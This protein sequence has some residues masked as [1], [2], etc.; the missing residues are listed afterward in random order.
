MALPHFSCSTVK[1]MCESWLAKAVHP[2]EMGEASFLGK[3]CFNVL[4]HWFLVESPQWLSTGTAEEP[5]FDIVSCAKSWD[6]RDQNRAR[7]RPP[8]TT[9][10]PSGRGVV[11]LGDR[12]RPRLL[13]DCQRSRPGETS[14]ASADWFALRGRWC[15]SILV[16]PLWE[17]VHANTGPI[18][19]ISHEPGL[20]SWPDKLHWL[21]PA[22]ACVLRVSLRLWVHCGPYQ[23]A[24][25][26]AN[27]HARIIILSGPF[28]WTDVWCSQHSPAMAAGLTDHIWTVQELLTSVFVPSSINTS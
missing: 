15:G 2:D 20:H 23:P 26:S 17:R 22:T 5:V 14:A 12:W 18:G 16:L 1:R 27:K 11:G 9:H 4:P 28:S 25:D 13:C 8:T 24:L 19:P 3:T 21:V 7:G 10:A 6:S